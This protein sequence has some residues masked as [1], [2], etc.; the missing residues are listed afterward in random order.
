MSKRGRKPLAKEDRKT[1][2]THLVLVEADEK[3]LQAFIAA[4]PVPP[5]KS[6]VVRV[7]VL[8]F[9]EKHGF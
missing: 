6:S 3:R 8:D 2:S 4:Q 1:G 9:L 5:T 7:A